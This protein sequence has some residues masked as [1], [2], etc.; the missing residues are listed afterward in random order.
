M[1]GP[2]LLPEPE[3]G[4]SR[5]GVPKLPLAMLSF[6]ALQ[7]GSPNPG[8]CQGA[9]R[10][11]PWLERGVV[12]RVQEGLTC[13]PFSFHTTGLPRASRAPDH[14]GPGLWGCTC[15]KTQR[16][17]SGEGVEAFSLPAPGWWWLHQTRTGRCLP[18]GPFCG[19]PVYQLAWGPAPSLQVRG[20]EARVVPTQTHPKPATSPGQPEFLWLIRPLQGPSRGA[21]HPQ[22]L[23]SMSKGCTLTPPN[24]SRSNSS[25]RVMF[26]KLGSTEKTLLV[27]GS[28]L[29]W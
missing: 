13:P 4:W 14:R 24:T 11:W 8:G 18:T 5:A 23:V 7:A 25:I 28:K 22:I 2:S 27:L 29:M 20:A 15:P 21:S 19:Q 10:K 3:R 12:G 16:D 1:G 26:P 6:R 9:G 17:F